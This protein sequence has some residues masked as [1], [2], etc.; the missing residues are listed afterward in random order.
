MVSPINETASVIASSEVINKN[1]NST[2]PNSGN[3]VQSEAVRQAAPKSEG[4]G[5]STKEG[6]KG[7]V[8]K[9][10]ITDGKLTISVYDSSGKL[11]R[12][13]PPGYLPAGEQQFDVTV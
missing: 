9:S 8:R 6:A 4:A 11:L 2:A 5:P 1:P 12:K 10:E 7:E 13:L 3:A